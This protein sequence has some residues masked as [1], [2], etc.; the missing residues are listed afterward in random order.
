MFTTPSHFDLVFEDFLPKFIC[1][2]IHKY[3]LKLTYSEAN[4]AIHIE[5]ICEKK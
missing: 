2:L 3:Q 4:Q 1:V 5:T